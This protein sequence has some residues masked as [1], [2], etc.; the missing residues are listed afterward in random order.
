MTET[1]AQL[2]ESGVLARVLQHYR[3][4]ATVILGPGDDSA[5]LRF[6]GDAVVTT[7]TMIEGNDFRL[8]WHE[9]EE[10]GWKLAAT[11]LSDVAAMGATPTAL[12]VALACPG[13]TP[14]SMLEGI[15]KGLQ[16]ACDVLAPGCS[17]AG[18]DLAK[19]EQIVCAITALGDLE[20]RA[21]VTR[22]GAQIGD[23]VAYAGELGMSRVGLRALF[24]EGRT[25]R[26]TV[27]E[28]VRAHLSPSTPVPLAIRASEVGA[29]AM[30]DVSDG[31]LLDSARLGKASHVTLNFSTTALSQSFGIQDGVEVSVEDLLIGGEDHGFLTTFPSADVVPSG[32]HVIGRVESRSE[33][34]L[35]DGGP[36]S[37]TGWDPFRPHPPA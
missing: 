12:T 3:D 2:G 18:G 7:D 32:F 34:V 17:V 26:N 31:L 20:G 29:T 35:I 27:R 19:A 13:D 24:D 14:V 11:N 8:D 25:A 36:T 4:G 28:A 6:Q 21:A 16:H 10:L 23:V 33:D 15:A 22:S 9:P 30:M 5:V 1:V 37:V